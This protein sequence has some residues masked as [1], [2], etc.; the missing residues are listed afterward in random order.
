MLCSSPKR[1]LL[2]DESADPCGGCVDEVWTRAVMVAAGMGARVR[3]RI[4][5]RGILRKTTGLSFAVRVSTDVRG[6]YP[7]GWTKLWITVETGFGRFR[8]VAD[9]LGVSR[10]AN[11]VCGGRRSHPWGSSDEPS[12]K[13]RSA[14]SG[15]PVRGSNLVPVPAPSF[16][17]SSAT[18]LHS[19]A[20]ACY[21]VAGR[22]PRSSSPS[23]RRL[24][25]RRPGDHRDGWFRG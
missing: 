14:S 17:S 18:E 25:E 15:A 19:R 5:D 22:G 21:P 6:P 10:T 16:P 1:A 4:E 3:L 9:E 11:P 2:V 24:P 13:A 8:E 12:A 7:Q 23:A 20:R